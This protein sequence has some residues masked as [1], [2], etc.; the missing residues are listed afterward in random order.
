M[1]THGKAPGSGMTCLRASDSGGHGH[2]FSSLRC[3]PLTAASREIRCRRD[4]P[5]ILFGLPFFLL[6]LSWESQPLFQGARAPLEV[7]VAFANILPGDVG[8]SLSGDALGRGRF[9]EPRISAFS[10]DSVLSGLLVPAPVRSNQVVGDSSAAGRNLRFR[11]EDGD[12]LEPPYASPRPFSQQKQYS[13]SRGH[14][15]VTGGPD[16]TG[17]NL[18]PTASGKTGGVAH[19]VERQIDA[20]ATLQAAFS[21]LARK[22]EGTCSRVCQA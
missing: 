13:F 18:P 4:L 19:E 7:V 15:D 10:S 21:Q 6:V 5:G 14:T 8:R 11:G 16:K 22:S 12:P 2:R 17:M 20:S 9:E 1:E 3:A